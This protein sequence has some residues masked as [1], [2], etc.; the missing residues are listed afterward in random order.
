MIIIAI[1]L[2]KES[3]QSL[4]KLINL[5]SIVCGHVCILNGC[6]CLILITFVFKQAYNYKS[7]RPQAENIDKCVEMASGLPSATTRLRYVEPQ[8]RSLIGCQLTGSNV[9]RKTHLADDE[10]ESHNSLC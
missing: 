5:L 4:E 3:H 7:H 2:L 6:T 8:T 9:G 1:Y 10:F